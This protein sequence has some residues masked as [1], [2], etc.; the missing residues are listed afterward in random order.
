MAAPIPSVL[1]QRGHSRSAASSQAR[2]PYS[3]RR[4]RVGAS[5]FFG[6]DISQHLMPLFAIHCANCPLP[7]SLRV[8]APFLPNRHQPDTVIPFAQQ[9]AE[10]PPA[11][12]PSPCQPPSPLLK[13]TNVC[14]PYRS[15]QQP[16]AQ[17]ATPH[18]STSSRRHAPRGC[19]FG[20]LLSKMPPTMRKVWEN[21]PPIR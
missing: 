11:P 1:P 6:G 5:S 18:R 17:F 16:A 20:T 8:H 21:S 7:A 19:T 13:L 2:P 14:H 4:H 9:P 3:P 10:P 12:H 15:R